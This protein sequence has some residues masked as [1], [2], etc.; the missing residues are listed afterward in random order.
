MRI[1]CSR[2]K[3]RLRLF[4]DLEAVSRLGGAALGRKGACHLLAHHLLDHARQVGLQPMA[5]DRLQQL[6][7]HLLERARLR[8]VGG[9]R[10]LGRRRLP[11]QGGRLVR[12][13]VGCDVAERSIGWLWPRGAVAGQARPLRP[14][15]GRASGMGAGSRA[16][17]AVGTASLG[18]ASVRVGGAEVAVG[19][20][21]LVCR[22]RRTASTA[23][24]APYAR[25]RPLSCPP[26]SVAE[27]RAASSLS[28]RC[29]PGP[30]AHAPAP[31]GRLWDAPP[32]RRT[33]AAGMPAGP[34]AA[35]A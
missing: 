15:Q 4:E 16:T 3:R 33:G 35:R 27:V 2:L 21:R 13:G 14:A 31:S 11:R 30:W 25:C 12:R 17:G 20:G 23:A 1:A 10:R 6:A 9:R 28:G 32:R 34:R 29:C 22:L 24:S 5:D 19:L 26:R 8:G 7:D 18:P